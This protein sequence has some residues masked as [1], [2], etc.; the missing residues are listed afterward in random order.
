MNRITKELSIP[1]FLLMFS[2]WVFLLVCPLQ[3]AGQP[4][5]PALKIPTGHTA[6]INTLA[7]SPDGKW[8]ASGSTDNSLIIWDARTGFDIRKINT[9]EPVWYISFPEDGSGVITVSGQ[10]GAEYSG[11]KSTLKKW[12][13]ATGKLLGQYSYSGSPELVPLPSQGGFLIA[14]NSSYLQK[15]TEQTRNMDLT[16]PNAVNKLDY[17]KM[18]NIDSMTKEFT[19]KMEELS[20]NGSKLDPNNKKAMEEYQRKLAEIYMGS[21]SPVNNVLKKTIGI[22]S[23]S[24]L[25]MTGKLNRA[26]EKAYLISYHGN[27]YIISPEMK[28]M[29]AAGE[30]RFRFEAWD[31]KEL[32]TANSNQSATPWK[33]Y[34]VKSNNSPVYTSRSGGF[35]AMPAQRNSMVQLWQLENT[36]ALAEFKVNGKVLH[37]VEFSPNGNQLYIFSQTPDNDKK[38]FYVEGWNTHTF[39]RDLFIT[40]PTN[41]QTGTPRVAPSGLYYINTVAYPGWTIKQFNWK[42][43]STGVLGGRAGAPSYFGFD[44]E[45]ATVY[46]NFLGFPDMKEFLLAGITASVE[47]EA[48]SKGIK[49]TKAERDKQVAD[50]L[51]RYPFYNQP[52]YYGYNL[53]WDLTTGGIK[54]T[55]AAAEF[56]PDHR[57]QSKDKNYSLRNLMYETGIQTNMTLIN[58]MRQPVDGVSEETMIILRRYYDTSSNFYKRVF[59]GR[60]NG[61][62][63]QLINSGHTTDQ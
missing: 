15:T 4:P 16:D 57:T 6:Q 17:S 44:G 43:D 9:G 27:E 22:L 13:L 21:Y 46:L 33:T 45:D 61:P 41:Y 59:A 24:T 10:V 48:F 40:M 23:S 30:S 62:V 60:L 7:F 49:L 47:H 20:K 53:V 55:Q 12:D 42:G 58:M 51:R 1:L 19:K 11:G 56:S 2:L 14:E 18:M 32:M 34:L 3:T 35:F 39:K 50:Q 38:Q 25:K 52:P 54:S 36:T 29:P 5:K 26:F 37:G 63:T 31:L 8:I 28:M